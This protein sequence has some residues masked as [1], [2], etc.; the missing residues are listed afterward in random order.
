MNHLK[1]ERQNKKAVL[2][3]RVS[4]D[5]QAIK[6]Y[7]LIDQEHVLKK[8]CLSDGVEIIE[9]FCDD[10]YSAKTFRR[11]AFER[12]LNML[13]EN[14]LKF[15]Y[16]YVVRWDRFSR[17][18]ENSYIMI[19]ELRLH[20][21][22]VICLE[23][24][25]DNSDPASVLL[26]AI[27][28]AEPE[29]DNRRRSI[30]T[31]MGIC[32]ALKE[33]R[34]ACGRAPLGY[35]WDRTMTKPTIVPNEL[36]LLVKE[37]FEMYSTG[38]Y[39]IEFVRKFIYN[40]GLKICKTA[41]NRLL[42]NPVYAGKIVVP[43]YNDEEKQIIGGLHE[44]IIS[45]DTFQ[46]TQ[47]ILVKVLEKNSSRIKKSN[48]NS[49]LPLRGYLQ[50]SKCDNTW[51]GSGSKGNGGVYYYYHCQNGCKE[52]IRVSEAN[53]AFVEYLKTFRVYPQIDQLYLKI[54]EDVFNTKEGD[55]E[56]QLTKIEGRIQELNKKLLKIDE[57]FINGDLEKDSYNRLKKSKQEEENKLQQSYSQ[58]KL[59]DTSFMKYCKYGT[60]LLKNLDLFYQEARPS[61]QKKLLGSI[62]TGK[63]I[64]EDGYYRTTK[65]NQ[66][67]ELMGLFQ[68][69]LGENKSEHL[70][71]SNKTFGKMPRIGLEPTHLTAPE[72]KSGV[73]TNFTTWA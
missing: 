51:T 50:C 32:R 35:S 61:V 66:A 24:T 57:M 30:N 65:L 36:A 5:E 1:K 55:R 15:D 59:A 2:Y 62:F 20:G 42:R 58:L 39:S 41:F 25:L 40:K 67:V 9:H 54:M 11:P 4:T 70:D 34:Y 37:A 46:K 72:P 63:L 10:G 45:E 13:K 38:L 3:T 33:G 29:M 69:E 12:M 49:E 31:S 44:A 16:L 17:N 60:S 23:E 56:Q 6:G 43:A 48:Y 14:K 8:A 71:I 19:K 27:K 22:E 47:H 21:I 53:N 26:R 28:L 73:S 7:S 68:K 64:F 52:R 18:I